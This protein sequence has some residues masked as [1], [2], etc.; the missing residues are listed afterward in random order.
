AS[1]PV[2]FIERLLAWEKWNDNHCTFTHA[3]TRTVCFKDIQTQRLRIYQNTVPGARVFFDNVATT[4][5]VEPGSH[6]HGRCAVSLKGQKVW[7]RQLNP[8]RGEPEIL[9]DGGDLL[10]MGYKSEG[11]GVVVHTIHGGRTEVIGGVVN[12]GN[13]ADTAF[14]AE[15]SEI[16]LST[17]THGWREPAYFRNALRHTRGDQ[18]IILKHEDLPSR[19]FEKTRGPQYLV[20]LYK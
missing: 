20:P 8:E 13:T 16:R 6:G 17:A 3:D 15:D 2:L 10:L 7:A 5:G 12:V 9:N 11:K 1:G 18:T 14:V 4:T 19:G